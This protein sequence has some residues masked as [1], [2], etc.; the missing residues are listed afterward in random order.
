[1]ICLQHFRLSPEQQQSLFS[2][3]LIG[4]VYSVMDYSAASSLKFEITLGTIQ[5][6]NK[7]K[8]L[9]FKRGLA[10]QMFFISCSLSFTAF[11]KD[12]EQRRKQLDLGYQPGYQHICKVTGPHGNT[13]CYF[14]RG[15]PEVLH[16]VFFFHFYLTFPYSRTMTL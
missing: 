3:N 4:D 10:T 11:R 5:E 8:L 12:S 1:M 16:R 7:E 9:F 2:I 13:A 15:K 14:K 6:M